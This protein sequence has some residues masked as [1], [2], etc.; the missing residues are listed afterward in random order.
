MYVGLNY[1]DGTENQKRVRQ[2]T[3]TPDVLDTS[4]VLLV[5][6]AIE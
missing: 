6:K 5:D 4:L 1:D 3:N 2:A